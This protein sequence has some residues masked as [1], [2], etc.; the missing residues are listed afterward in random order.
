MKKADLEQEIERLKGLCDEKDE[1]INKQ[2]TR[3]FKGK[4]AVETMDVVGDMIDGVKICATK[5]DD[6]ID[7]IMHTKTV[8]YIKTQIRLYNKR[9]KAKKILLYHI[10]ERCK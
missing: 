9:R 1:I 10:K 8:S 7:V 5:T 2:N 6:A 3:I 4:R